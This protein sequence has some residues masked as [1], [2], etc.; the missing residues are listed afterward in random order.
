[1]PRKTGL[2]FSIQRTY[3][4]AKRAIFVDMPDVIC[5]LKQSSV[6]YGFDHEGERQ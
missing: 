3:P 4:R 5:P 6:K 2:N 1:M